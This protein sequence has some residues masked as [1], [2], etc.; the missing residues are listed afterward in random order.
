MNLG[1]QAVRVRIG[2]FL[3]LGGAAITAVA[4]V[5]PH[6]AQLDTVGFL[7]VAMLQVVCGLVVL[8]LPAR[9]RNGSWIPPAIVMAGVPAGAPPPLFH[10][11]RPRGPPGVHEVFSF[12]RPFF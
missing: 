12:L 6:S 8:T 11:A 10:R 5:A 1:R 4:T 7:V 9:L 2:A 3:F